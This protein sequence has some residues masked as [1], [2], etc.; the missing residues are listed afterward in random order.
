MRVEEAAKLNKHYT[1]VIVLMA[2]SRE[3]LQRIVDEF[4]RACDRMR[5]TINKLIKIKR[6]WPGRFIEI[7]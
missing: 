3:V 1:Q 2:E 7:I 5:L 4:E 6:W